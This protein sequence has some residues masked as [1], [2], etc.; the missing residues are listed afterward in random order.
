MRRNNFKEKK[1]IPLL[2]KQ[3][4]I[5][6]YLNKLDRLTPQD[7]YVYCLIYRLSQNSSL[8]RAMAFMYVSWPKIAIDVLMEIFGPKYWTIIMFAQFKI[9]SLKIRKLIILLNFQ[10][11][12]QQ[13]LFWI[14][15]SVVTKT[16]FCDPLKT[17]SIN[18]EEVVR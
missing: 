15:N 10:T 3:F 4:W 1:G 18:E 13:T 17:Q 14:K 7:V 2:F 16:Y 5:R 6:S 11:I 12:W 9:L 8:N